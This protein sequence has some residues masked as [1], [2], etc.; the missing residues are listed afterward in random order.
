MHGLIRALEDIVAYGRHTDKKSAKVHNAIFALDYEAIVKETRN[1]KKKELRRQAKLPESERDTIVK[2]LSSDVVKHLQQRDITMFF[3]REDPATISEAERAWIEVLKALEAIDDSPYGSDLNAAILVRQSDLTPLESCL[4]RA[5]A[6]AKRLGDGLELLP[7]I[8]NTKRLSTSDRIASIAAMGAMIEDSGFRET[9]VDDRLEAAFAIYSPEIWDT[10]WH[11]LAAKLY[12]HV[13]K[14]YGFS[15]A[16]PEIRSKAEHAKLGIDWALVTQHPRQGTRALRFLKYCVRQVEPQID[17]DWVAMKFDELIVEA[18]IMAAE[19]FVRSSEEVEFH[20]KN[21]GSA[22]S[23]SVRIQMD[24]IAHFMNAAELAQDLIDQMV[25]GER[26]LDEN[27]QIHLHEV[28]ARSTSWIAQSQF[29][30]G[31]NGV[32]PPDSSDRQFLLDNAAENMITARE[33]ELAARGGGGSP[34]KF[35]VDDVVPT[36]LEK[37]RTDRRTVLREAPRAEPP[38][39]QGLEIGHELINS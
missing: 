18:E 8:L 38:S 13:A 34:F 30:I 19:S 15:P 1:A 35:F 22:H 23:R 4:A 32:L 28:V 29:L 20:Q 12:P 31:R 3:D 24:A 10:A 25:E 33:H 36:Y 17:R 9:N 16:N 14:H 6:Y 37:F 2:G 21:D 5:F 7:F 11:P 39:I 26:P 27:V